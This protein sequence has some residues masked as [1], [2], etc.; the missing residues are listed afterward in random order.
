MC[1]QIVRNKDDYSISIVDVMLLFTHK[2]CYSLLERLRDITIPHHYH[3]IY[4]TFQRAMSKVN[5]FFMAWYMHFYVCCQAN[6]VTYGRRSICA[7]ST[8]RHSS[9]PLCQ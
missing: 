6:I 5:V 9:G 1:V 3:T 8:F 4:I 7:F 2:Q